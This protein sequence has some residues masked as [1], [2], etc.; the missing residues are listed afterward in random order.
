MYIHVRSIGK[1][2]TEIKLMMRVKYFFDKNQKDDIDLFCDIQGNIFAG[3]V[4]NIT[5]ILHYCYNS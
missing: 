1:N 5:L 4:F 3:F 2:V